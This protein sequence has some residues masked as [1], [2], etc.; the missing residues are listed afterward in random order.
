M[1]SAKAFL[2]EIVLPF[3]A[4]GGLYLLVAMGC[5]AH[6]PKGKVPPSDALNEAGRNHFVAD[7]ARSR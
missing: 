4:V 2:K 6:R 7:L 1:K 3:A 5:Q